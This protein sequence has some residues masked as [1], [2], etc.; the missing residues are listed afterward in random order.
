MIAAMFLICGEAVIDLF[1]Q[2]GESDL[3][4]AGQIAGSPLNV[5]IGLS[6]LG[7]K[8]SFMTGISNDPFGTRVIAALTREKVGWEFAQR[9]DRPTI[10]AFV[11][12]K[13][14]GGPDYTFYGENGA[15][16][17]VRE[18][19]LPAVLPQDIK[20]IHLAGFPLAIE[21]SK[22]AYAALIRR[23]AKTR[24]I[25]LDPN[26]RALLMG[27]LD[28]FRDHFETLVPSSHLIKASAEDIEALYPSIDA[29]TIAKRWRSLGCGTV[30]ITDGA[31][32][33]FA[34][35][36]HGVCQSKTLPVTVVDTVGAGDSFM[37]A[38]L[39]KLAENDLLS[40]GV[41]AKAPLTSLKSMMDFA[42]VA[43]GITC[44]R[45]GANPPTRDE[46]SGSGQS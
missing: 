30:I 18:E 10:I 2:G 31:K 7:H 5:A 46:L 38:M 4:F 17:D 22:S 9:T 42:N 6:R 40:Q 33:A 29:L 41:L 14:D 3:A 32:G 36:A 23:E 28:I 26:I 27:D 45:Q 39:A 34:L 20:A 24:F 43:A 25:S 19:M 37:S 44:S 35:N 15:D 11:M 13:P 16:F 1:Q 12:V 21:T 8:S